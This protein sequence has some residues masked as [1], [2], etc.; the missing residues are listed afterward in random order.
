MNY[1]EG[2]FT[3]TLTGVTGTVSGTAHWVRDNQVVTLEIPALSGTSLSTAATLT[4]LPVEIR[5]PRPQVLSGRV[6]NNG[7]L[8]QGYV[9][10]ETNGSI[11]LSPDAV[12]GLFSAVLGK[13]IEAATVSYHMKA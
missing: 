4:G 7:V 2:S 6:Q 1:A 10:I 13:G 5:P 3:V 8:A 12:F 11:T 9:R